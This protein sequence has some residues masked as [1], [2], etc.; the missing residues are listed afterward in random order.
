LHQFD[1]SISN[2]TS[3]EQQLRMIDFNVSQQLAF[4]RI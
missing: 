4:E 1:Q 2:A 3:L